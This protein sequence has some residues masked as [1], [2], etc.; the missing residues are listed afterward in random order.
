MEYAPGGDL[1]WVAC[2]SDNQRIPED[3]ARFYAAELLLALKHLHSVGYMH[4]DIKPDNVL[5]DAKGHCKLGDFGFARKVDSNGRCHSHLGTPHYLA[6][7]QLDIHNKG[8]YSTCVDWWSFAV[9]LYVLVAGNGPFGK[10]SD[11]RYEVYLKVMKVRKASEGAARE[12]STVVIV[13]V[14][15]YSLIPSFNC[16]AVYG[17]VAFQQAQTVYT[18]IF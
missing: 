9:T 16:N 1:G 2:R 18:K 4:R 12:W 3:D 15:F 5:I 10:N 11:T 17:V 14:I 8:G 6:P 7:E 13:I